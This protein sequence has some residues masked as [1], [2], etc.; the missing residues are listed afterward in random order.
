LPVTLPGNFLTIAM[1]LSSDQFATLSQLLDEGLEL[2]EPDRPAW[3]EELP[4][5]FPGAKVLLQKMLAGDESGAAQGLLSM[6]PSLATSSDR[7][8]AEPAAGG[9][10]ADAR[11]CNYR[12][13]REIGHGG[14]STVWLAMRTDELVTRPVALKL[15]HVHLQPAL[16]ADRF[17]RER[18]ILANLTHPN[19]A[20]LYD[21]GISPQG[22]PFLA[23]EFVGGE[24]LTSYCRAHGLDVTQRIELFL[25]VL[26]AVQHAHTQHIIH[27]DLK[28]SNILVREGAQVVLLDFG[29]AKLL[30]EGETTATD[31]TRQGGAAFTP[32]YASPEQIRGETLG[33]ATDIYSLGVVLY[34]LL[35]SQRPY[36]LRRGSRRDIED[37]VLSSDPLRPSD[38]LA[39]DAETVRGRTSPTLSRSAL[40]GDLDTIVLKAMKKH[41]QDRYSSV[42][43]FAEDLRR[44]LRHEPVSARPDTTWYR[45]NRMVQRHRNALLTATATIAV[46]GAVGGFAIN[47]WLIRA[48]SPSAF[49][50]PPR[51]IAVLPLQNLSGDA[52]QDYISDGISEELLDELS[53]LNGLQVV[54]RTS[55]FSFKGRG[56]DAQTIAR[57]LNVA[58]ILEGSVRRAGNAMRIAIH[59]I[60]GANGFQLWSQTYDRNSNDIL[61]LQTEIANAVA[62]RVGG[63]QV[64]SQVA[65]MARGGTE[66]ADAY[67]AYL[68]G[69]RLYYMPNPRVATYQAAVAAFDQ[70]IAADPGYAAAY[71]RKSGALYRIFGRTADAAVRAQL[72]SEA[73]QAA[74]R[75]VELAPNLGDSHLARAFSFELGDLNFGE[76]A[77]E[78]DRALE[79]SPGSAWVLWNVGLFESQSGQFD[80]ALPALDKAIQ[81]DPQNAWPREMRVRVLLRARRFRDALT[82][83][84]EASALDPGSHHIEERRLEA[85][86][87]LRQFDTV[88][89]QCE[90]RSTPLDDDDRYYLLAIA[91]HML[92]RHAEAE[93]F[94]KQF[95]ALDGDSGAFYYA[96]I[97]AQW[98]DPKMALTWLQKALEMLDPSMEDLKTDWLLDPIRD[99]PQFRA[100]LARLNFAA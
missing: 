57:K 25:Q 27:R 73:R 24:S 44:H 74:Q 53:R 80:R 55:S 35:T 97:Y 41:P 10:E 36:V 46:T 84:Q 12:L 14:M 8:R 33:P 92:G 13:V 72:N 78:Y 50:P 96:E 83:A 77:A 16:F 31:L 38:A 76:A 71:A 61:A 99:E 52:D 66:S 90:A 85:L 9:F 39:A 7:D 49:A 95:Q 43:A 86:L 100:L 69:L 68:R 20:H 59:M 34:E 32:D 67:D 62:E 30:I 11:I 81:L 51:S 98:G 79:L 75:A 94:L 5:P 1:R 29:I 47:H 40:R 45:V 23:M 42:D 91:Y 48:D 26:S 6:L 64:A 4:D 28:P 56:I 37:A 65:V 22:Q 70:A 15:P 3:L 17:A 87:G 2:A 58:T 82:S 19:I 18:D 93:R 60:N 21:A 63:P 89:Q 54:A 88:R